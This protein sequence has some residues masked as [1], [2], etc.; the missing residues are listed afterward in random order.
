MA[1]L[2]DAGSIAPAGMDMIRIAQE[3]GAWTALDAV[4]ELVVPEDLSKAFGKKPKAFRNWEQ[5]PRSVKRGILEQLLN[6]KK[7]ETRAARIKNIVDAAA[8]NL[9]F[10]FR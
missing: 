10:G 8:E 1:R 6:A 4:E 9:R 5:F 3:N 2:I 7:A